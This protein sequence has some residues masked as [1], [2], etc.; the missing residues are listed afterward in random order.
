MK[1]LKYEVGIR[2][3]LKYKVGIRSRLRN[4]MGIK[5]TIS[6]NNVMNIQKMKSL[7]Y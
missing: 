7:K 2:T 6:L 4:K 5:Q 1:S 3:R